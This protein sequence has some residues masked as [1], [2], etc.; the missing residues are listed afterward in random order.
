MILEENIISN[1]QSWKFVLP[2][3]F[4]GTNIWNICIKHSIAAG[5]WDE[6]SPYD[7]QL[8][9]IKTIAIGDWIVAYLKRKTIGGIGRVICTYDYQA[10][11][12]KPE[13]SDYFHGEFWHRI[14]VKWIPVTINID[15]L[16]KS[17]QNPFRTPITLLRIKKSVLEE[18][19][20]NLNQK[21]LV[22]LKVLL[23]KND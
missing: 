17:S 14:G 23:N 2:D 19:L 12:K 10:A 15:V 16:S 3:D 6:N 8:K 22:A 5:N 18:I 7:F 13:I 1:E 4:Q 11:N 9:H 20:N 21:E